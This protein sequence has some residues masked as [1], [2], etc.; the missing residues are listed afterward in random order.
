[1]ANSISSRTS[2]PSRC[3]C[4]DRHHAKFAVGAHH[5]FGARAAGGQVALPDRRHLD[6]PSGDHLSVTRNVR[7]ISVAIA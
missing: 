7:S 2:C 3:G 1:M 4:V 5:Y 6:A